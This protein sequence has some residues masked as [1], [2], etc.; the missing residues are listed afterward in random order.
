MRRQAEPLSPIGREAPRDRVTKGG[1]RGCFRS[2]NMAHKA[3]HLNEE[4]FW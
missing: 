2:Q 4:S 3:A 1:Y